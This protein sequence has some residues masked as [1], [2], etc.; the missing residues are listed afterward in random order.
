MNE[1]VFDIMLDV[2][3]KPDGDTVSMTYVDRLLTKVF[4]DS[5]Y[6]LEIIPCVNGH[7][8]L[9]LKLTEK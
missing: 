1:I 6:K 8:K 3:G 7:Y 2:I 5:S 9:L 4:K